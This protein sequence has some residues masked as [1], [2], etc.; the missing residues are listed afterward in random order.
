MDPPSI[1]YC[2]YLF[3][4][5]GLDGP[6][7]KRLLHQFLND[8]LED[9]PSPAKPAIN[10]ILELKQLFKSCFTSHLTTDWQVT[11]QRFSNVAK[12]VKILVTP[13]LHVMICHIEE[14]C[15]S[16][17]SGLGKYNEQVHN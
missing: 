3:E 9:C 14:S 11:L 10:A 8:L 6:R 12:Q 15:L 2:I 13:K 1:W 4:I 17:N 5:L 7:C 16:T